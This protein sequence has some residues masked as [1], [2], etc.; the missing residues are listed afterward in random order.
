MTDSLRRVNLAVAIAQSLPILTSAQASR[1]PQTSQAPQATKSG[2]KSRP[3][4]GLTQAQM[5]AQ[6]GP[7]A[8]TTA[9]VW[10]FNTLTGPLQVFFKNGVVSETRSVT[11]PKSYKNV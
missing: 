7:P 11:P 1:T 4:L 8:T 5:K 9:S 10:T 6:L 3:L 2:T